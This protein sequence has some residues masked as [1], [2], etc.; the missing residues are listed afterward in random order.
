LLGLDLLN[1]SPDVVKRIK[2]SANCAK[3]L[4]NPDDEKGHLCSTSWNKLYGTVRCGIFNSNH[5][6]SDRFVWRRAQSCLKFSSPYVI[7]EHEDCAERDVIELA[8]YT[9][10]NGDIPYESQNQGRLLKIFQTKVKVETWYIY[11][12][13]IK[14]LYSEY[15]LLDNDENLLESVT[16]YH[17]D[18]G[19]S[20]YSG[21]TQNLYFG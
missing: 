7:G 6:D 11:K 2:F 3:Y 9:Y 16:I 12:I 13:L 5:K 8:A 10:D 21:F 18:C 1:T 15:Q 20:Y 19:S 17:R 14:Q 4:F